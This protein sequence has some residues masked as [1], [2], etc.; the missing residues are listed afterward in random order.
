MMFTFNSLSSTCKVA[1]IR[2]AVIICHL[3]DRIIHD[4]PLD[5]QLWFEM[6]MTAFTLTLQVHLQGDGPLRGTRQHCHRVLR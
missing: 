3:C 1:E 4:C 2:L 5:S 6:A